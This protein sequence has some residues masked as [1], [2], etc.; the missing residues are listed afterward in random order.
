MTGL[1]ASTALAA[2]LSLRVV[3]NLQGVRLSG[4]WYVTLPAM[5]L[6]AYANSYGFPLMVCSLAIGVVN[7]F[8]LSGRFKVIVQI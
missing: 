8:I 3:P 1:L 7:V 6:S 2:M 5:L 4:Y